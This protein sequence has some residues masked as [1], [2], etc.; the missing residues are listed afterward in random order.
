MMGLGFLADLL[1]L[2]KVSFNLVQQDVE[3]YTNRALIVKSIRKL[4]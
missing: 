3:A 1:S 2:Y 4:F